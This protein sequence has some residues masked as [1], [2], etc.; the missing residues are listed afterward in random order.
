MSR[1]CLKCGKSTKAC[2][3]QWID[4]LAPS[5]GLIILQHPTEAKKPMGTA[6][7]L[8]L[9]LAS[10]Y[11][12][13]GENFTQHEEFNRLLSDNDYQHFVLYPSDSSLSFSKV[14]QAIA[15]QKKVRIILLDGTWKK[16]YKIW[17][18][19]KNLKD[20]PMIH[21]PKDL[22]GNYRIR[23]APSDNNLSTVE[24]GYHV[25]SLLEPERDFSAL[26]ETFN[27]MID[28]QI[29]HMPPGTFE[30]NHS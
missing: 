6:K 13:Q 16:A 2:I 9:S 14:R 20:L 11:L 25:L 12:F 8:K 4:N 27:R 18:L 30:K 22:K 5:V 1:Y 3:C 7:I 10:S 28:F 19:S 21:L 23:K 29:K 24:A 17:Q 26:L 15:Y